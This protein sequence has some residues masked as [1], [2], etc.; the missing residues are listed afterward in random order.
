MSQGWHQDP[1]TDLHTRLAVVEEK[2]K[3][4]VTQDEFKPIRLFVYGFMSL[5]MLTVVGI[6]LS[7]T[8]GTK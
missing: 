8:I 3:D 4:F 6:V 7:R 1:M 2:I 5:V